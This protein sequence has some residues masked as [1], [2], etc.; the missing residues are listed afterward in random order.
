MEGFV[1]FDCVIEK[2]DLLQENETDFEINNNNNKNEQDIDFA[3][4]NSEVKRFDLDHF[5][6]GNT[7]SVNI[8]AGKDVTWVVKCLALEVAK[9]IKCGY[10]ETN[11]S[12]SISRCG[13]KKYYKI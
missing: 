6:S 7:N 5:S 10:E 9:V 8:V 1:L 12:F 4:T 11:Y 2:I 3:I 13:G